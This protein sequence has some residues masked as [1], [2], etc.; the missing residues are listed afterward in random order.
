MSSNTPKKSVVLPPP[1]AGSSATTAQTNSNVSSGASGTAFDLTFEV[2]QVRK[3]LELEGATPQYP[4]SLRASLSTKELLT[5][6]KEAT[7]GTEAKF[8]MLKYENLN[9]VASANI[10]KFQNHVDME[11]FC[12]NVCTQA[13]KFEFAKLLVEFPVLYNPTNI[14]KPSHRFRNKKTVNRLKQPDLIRKTISIKQIGDAIEWIRTYASTSSAI[15]L[16]DLQWSHEYLINCCDD[17]LRE[18]I[19]SDLNH[20]FRPSE[21]GGPLTFALIISKTIN[22]SEDA[23]DG[24]KKQFEKFNLK[25][26]PGEDIKKVV[27]YFLVSKNPYCYQHTMGNGKIFK[28]CDHCHRNLK[29]GRWTTSHFT[30]QHSDSKKEEVLRREA[31]KKKNEDQANVA[32]TSG[33]S[34]PSGTTEDNKK[35]S[36]SQ[37]LSEAMSTN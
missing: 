11:T 22:L 29:F 10:K 36:F 18:S 31:D 6:Q 27:T 24:L 28:W 8:S 7:T 2:V 23:I 32:D 14:L 1:P 17:E 37:Q 33:G 13:V 9:G 16:Q 12:T 34:T 20:D 30:H 5:L 3:G 21:T 15:F 26:L 4:K 19:I 25:T 35:I